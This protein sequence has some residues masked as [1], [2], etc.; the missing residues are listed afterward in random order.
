[1]TAL[2]P[3][4][5]FAKPPV[6]IILKARTL[7]HRAVTPVLQGAHHVQC[8]L[9]SLLQLWAFGSSVYT[10]YVSEAHLVL[11]VTMY[12][13]PP[14]LCSHCCWSLSYRGTRHQA[15]LLLRRGHLVGSA[16]Q[17]GGAYAVGQEIPEVFDT[18]PGHSVERFLFSESRAWAQQ[19]SIW[20]WQ[21]PRQGVEWLAGDW[22]SPL[23]L[24]L[25]QG[26]NCHPEPCCLL[27]I[28]THQEGGVHDPF[29]S[30]APN[31]IGQITWYGAVDSDAILQVPST[32]LILTPWRDQKQFTCQ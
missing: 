2:N 8:L 23:S 29:S 1:M 11:A 7:Q 25:F 3:A 24:T 15:S 28:S 9:C 26:V 27:D 31:H 4:E 6:Y 21:P 12:S 19:T 17:S 5:I 32:A 10:P 18:P 16:S 30:T 20:E 22:G 14:C 13:L